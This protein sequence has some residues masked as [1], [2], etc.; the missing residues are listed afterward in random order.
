MRKRYDS[1]QWIKNQA[2]ELRIS[3]F[4]SFSE[5]IKKNYI[6]Q[7]IIGINKK[8]KTQ[9]KIARK[10][11]KKN[12]QKKIVCGDFFTKKKIIYKCIYFEFITKVS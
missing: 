9:K 8:L 2:V 12:L 4:V 11:Q 1:A 3:F 7:W 6:L 5:K 10:N